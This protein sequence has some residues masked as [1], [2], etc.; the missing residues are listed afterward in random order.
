VTPLITNL[1][2]DPFERFHTARGFDEWQENRSWTLA[3][4]TKM[5]Q[6]FVASFKEFPPRQGS[7]D[8]DTDSLLAPVTHPTSDD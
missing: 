2:L 1:A 6:K 5:I 4:S 3:P 7:F 8:L